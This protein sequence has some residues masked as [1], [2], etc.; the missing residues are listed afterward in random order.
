MTATR[1]D[2]NDATGVQG[3]A[4]NADVIY[5][6]AGNDSINAADAADTIETGACDDL[7]AS[8]GGNASVLNS[9]G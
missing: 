9:G 3:T 6:G 4:G 5:A 2:N 1:V 8:Y 7:V